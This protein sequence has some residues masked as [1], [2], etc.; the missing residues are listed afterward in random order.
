[1]SNA[2]TNYLQRAVEL[3]A[4]NVEKGG[5][6]FGAVLV[7]DSGW[8]TEAVNEFVTDH[9]PT[10]HA[11]IQALRHAAREHG[12]LAKFN[13]LTMYANGKPCPMCMAAMVNVGV[14]KIVFAAGDDIGTPYG[15][16][17]SASYNNMRNAFGEQGV[18]VEYERVEQ[19]KDV[20]QRWFELNPTEA[21]AD[22]A[23]TTTSAS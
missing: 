4:E 2:E 9:D 22:A 13:D 19:A 23:E 1:M 11:E 16:D 6:P 21:Q 8:V 10:A 12:D 14:K 18:V 5:F 7:S 3:A 20:Y 17:T 15:W